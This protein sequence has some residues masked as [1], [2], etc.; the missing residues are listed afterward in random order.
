MLRVDI[1]LVFTIINLLILFIALRIFL[2]KPVQKIIAQ[3]QADADK[4]F[5]DA[6]KEKEEAAKLKAEYEK[7]IENANTEKK[8]VISDAR[9]TANKEYQRIIDDANNQ[10]KVIREEA[11]RDANTQK[12][13]II[14]NAKQEIA[15]LVVNA[16]E[17]IIASKDGVDK[18]IYDKFLDKAGDK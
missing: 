4:E 13:R 10:A 17:K 2:F 3:R 18:D 5:D 11:I 1:N 12:D 9:K 15:D 14:G 6:A 16:T 8:I 7:T